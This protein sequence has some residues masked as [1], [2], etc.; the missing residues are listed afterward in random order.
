M[1]TAPEH[2]VYAFKSAAV[3]RNLYPEFPHDAGEILWGVPIQT[4][5]AK[6]HETGQIAHIQS[7]KEIRET[8]ASLGLSKTK[9]G[10]RLRQA[11]QAVYHLHG[12]SYDRQLVPP[13]H[14]RKNS[15]PHTS[16][17]AELIRSHQNSTA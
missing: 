4:A 6:Q 11:D 8:I 15:R 12:A 3:A 16:A 17:N 9:L 14:L 1:A 13:E 7:K 5:Q 2:R 10:L